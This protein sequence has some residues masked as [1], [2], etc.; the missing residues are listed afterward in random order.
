M[1]SS[2]VLSPISSPPS[3]VPDYIYIPAG[4]SQKIAGELKHF[5]T[6]E[7]RTILENAIE[8]GAN[9]EHR[10]ISTVK[11]SHRIKDKYKRAENI[12]ILEARKELID[13]SIYALMEGYVNSNSEHKF[14]GNWANLREIKIFLK[15]NPELLD[16]TILSVGS[17]SPFLTSK[18]LSD[19]IQRYSSLEKKPD[20]YVGLTSMDKLVELNNKL[21]LR[22]SSIDST[23]NNYCIT[24]MGL[25]RIS[26]MYIIK[27]FKLLDTGVIGSLQKVYDHRKLSQGITQ[28]LG[29]LSGFSSFLPRVLAHPYLTAKF[30]KDI[31]TSSRHFRGNYLGSPIKLE[32]AFQNTSEVTGLDVRGDINCGVGPL[33]DIDDEA[34][35][36][37][38][39]K[40]YGEISD[41]I[42]SN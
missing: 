10:I 22:V 6:L 27:P 11:E 32:K 26:N 36:N 24:D 16:L 30:A 4:S 19:F 39:K 23:L 14:T 35:Y 1:N 8:A 18:D 17:D 29:I 5:L 41:Y 20:I 40:H 33:L 25:F 12:Q 2:T 3:P 42:L 9:L 7:N 34:S 15:K 13:S 38:F 21:K 28:Y 37:F 31:L